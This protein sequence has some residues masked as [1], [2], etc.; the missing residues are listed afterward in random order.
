[1]ESKNY[2]GGIRGLIGWMKPYKWKF[3]VCGVNVAVANAAELITPMLTALIIDEFLT[4]GTPQSWAYSVPGLAVLS[5]SLLVLGAFCTVWESRLITRVSQG[6]LREMRGAV[7]RKILH[8]PT[9][10]LDENGTGKLITRATNDVEAINEFYSDV[11][12]N[13]FKDAFLLVGIVA[14]MLAVDVKLALLALAGVPVICVLVFSLKRLVRENHK[15]IKA[16]TGRLNGFIAESIGGMRTIHAFV[17]EGQKREEFGGS[18]NQLYRA[19]M[20]HLLLVT[21]LRPSM[22]MINHLVVALLIAFSYNRIAGGLLEVGVLYAFTTYVGKFFAPINDLADKYT[23]IQSTFVSL[24]RINGV[25]SAGPGEDLMAGEKSG[26]VRGDIAFR[27]VWFAYRLGEWVL[28]GVSFHIRAGEKAAFVG[29]TGAGKSTILSLMTRCYLPQKGQILVDGVDINDWRLQDLRRGCA[30][31]LQD[32]FLFTGT[33]RD[34]IDMQAGLG[35]GEIRRALIAA[36]CG[37]QD[38]DKRVYEQGA[39][40]STGERQLLSF[41]RAVASR[42]A[43][44]M[45]DEATAHIDTQT[46]ETLQRAIGEISRGRTCVF[47]AHRLSTI[48]GCDVIFVLEDGK[49]TESGSHEELLAL[50]GT[51]ADMDRQNTFLS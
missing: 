4:A 7:F 18:N 15:Q 46:E 13:L 14:S 32:I 22:E 20:V 25:L 38:L 40:F 12:I 3:A 36:Q 9:A 39:N 47:I 37:G 48:R 5:F 8:M 51:Y 42:P 2:P 17:R 10:Q 19:N 34:N 29:A 50:G 31:V 24:D 45:L 35:D 27:D 41:A 21:I 23:T 16:L 30:T 11:F 49:I 43:V 28:K 44:L 33:V 26:P 1:M 6:I